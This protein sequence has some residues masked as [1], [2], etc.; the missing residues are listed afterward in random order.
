MNKFGS[1]ACCRIYLFLTAVF[2]ILHCVTTYGDEVNS[3]LEID[4]S[5]SSAIGEN[6]NNSASIIDSLVIIEVS[7]KK[8]GSSGS[9][10]VVEMD[11]K[12][13]VVTNQHILDC[14]N[15]VAVKTLSNE[16]IVPTSFEVCKRL[17]LLRMEITNDIPA[18]VLLSGKPAI[19]EKAS[20][21]GNSDGAGVATEIRGKLLGVGPDLIEVSA[22]FVKGNSGCPILN[23]KK[24]V[25]GVASFATLYKDPEDWVSVG[26][27]YQEV[28]RYGIRLTAGEWLA[29]SPKKFKYE[30][31]ALSD[32]EKE[33]L[34]NA[35]TYL[36]IDDY[37]PLG[38]DRRGS[39]LKVLCEALD[40]S[41]DNFFDNKIYID[42]YK[43][44]KIVSRETSGFS[45]TQIRNGYTRI[46][47]DSFH[48]IQKIKKRVSSMK[49]TSGYASKKATE[50]LSMCNYVIEDYNK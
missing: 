21:Y 44:L 29:I 15:A 36:L 47:G 27:R 13:Y 16:L 28:R 6:I 22:E 42:C 32:L 14:F 23:A 10:F 5:A 43:H 19:G 4:L 41:S 7:T 2:F 46:R 30:T 40:V 33:A 34:V 35:V 26:T 9:G 17:D 31:I 11:G 50:I 20:I 38:R 37:F 39:V 45:R 24:E 49:I 25:M 8:G 48:N 18:L 3:D 12:K 1:N